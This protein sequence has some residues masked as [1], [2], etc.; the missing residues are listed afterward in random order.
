[1]LSERE[2]KQAPSHKFPPSFLYSLAILFGTMTNNNPNTDY[3]RN[4]ARSIIE[5]GAVNGYTW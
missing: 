4:S 1:M 2:R 3:S 5:G